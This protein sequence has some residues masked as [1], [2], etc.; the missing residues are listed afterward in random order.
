MRWKGGQRRPNRAGHSPAKTSYPSSSPTSFLESPLHPSTAPS[1]TPGT[2]GKL[3][4]G[5]PRAARR[6]AW[7]HLSKLCSLSILL[8]WFLV[9]IT[10]SD[11]DLTSSSPC[12]FAQA[13]FCFCSWGEGGPQ[14]LWLPSEEQAKSQ[15]NFPYTRFLAKTDEEEW[16]T[17]NSEGKSHQG[18]GIKGEKNRATG[19]NHRT[20]SIGTL[21]PIP[22]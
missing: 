3:L 21:S 12:P 7:G 11:E 18:D 17:K 20:R 1:P 10:P 4:F 15:R 19:R 13:V 2:K 22:S 16:N 9:I 8:V 5:P 6:S 14:Q